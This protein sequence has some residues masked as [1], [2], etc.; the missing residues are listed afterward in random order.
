MLTLLS[1]WAR[2]SS[3]CVITDHIQKKKERIHTKDCGKLNV[4]MVKSGRYSGFGDGG[5]KS[6]DSTPQSDWE[7]HPSCPWQ[8]WP[9]P[10]SHWSSAV[11]SSVPPAPTCLEPGSVRN[12]TQHFFCS[13]L[14]SAY[15]WRPGQKGA[16]SEQPL[17]HTRA[18]GTREVVVDCRSVPPRRPVAQ[19][20]L[21]I[22]ETLLLL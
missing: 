16:R 17:P 5:L 3:S 9:K 11:T 19:W 18:P 7:L 1:K 20:V 4:G 21:H 8:S 12:V 13:P 15:Y 10:P 2:K 6:P 14:L 22:S